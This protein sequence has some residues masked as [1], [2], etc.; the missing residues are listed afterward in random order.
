MKNLPNAALRDLLTRMGACDAS[1]YW[2]GYS[3][4][5][6]QA[7]EDVEDDSWLDWFINVAAW[8][9]K[10]WWI[11]HGVE[12]TEFTGLPDIDAFYEVEH[13]ALMEF[14]MDERTARYT[15]EMESKQSF[16]RYFTAQDRNL[17]PDLTDD[18]ARALW[19]THQAELADISATYTATRNAA[20]AKYLRAIKSIFVIED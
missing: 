16:N 1:L 3:R 6:R 7:L 8:S 17:H 14:Q 9:V 15:A 10:E 11:T 4:D 5:L 13:K 12:S 20:R 18:E 19:K 2:L